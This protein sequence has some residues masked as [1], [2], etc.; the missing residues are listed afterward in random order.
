MLICRR[1]GGVVYWTTSEAENVNINEAASQTDG[2][3]IRS[4]AA[5]LRRDL[6]QA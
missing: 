6:A 4:T 5:H 1:P 2:A 3:V